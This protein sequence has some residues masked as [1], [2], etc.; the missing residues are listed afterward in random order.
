LNTKLSRLYY[1]RLLN[2]KSSFQKV[3]NAK[4]YS[5]KDLTPNPLSC[6]EGAFLAPKAP[7][8][9]GEGGR[10]CGSGVRS[11][12]KEYLVVAFFLDNLIN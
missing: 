10:R 1:C 4:D 8:S 9:A 5:A 12:S 6:K 11:F 3:F 2:T 7:L